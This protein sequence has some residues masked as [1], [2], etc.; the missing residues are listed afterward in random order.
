MHVGS[1]QQRRPGGVHGG[2]N[3]SGRLVHRPW[4]T[5]QRMQARS[6]NKDHLRRPVPR[7]LLLTARPHLH[8]LQTQYYQAKTKP[9]NHDLCGRHLRP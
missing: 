1:S 6:R 8:S 5:K 9:S 2:K 7:D 4:A 3:T